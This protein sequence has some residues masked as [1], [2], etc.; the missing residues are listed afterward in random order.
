MSQEKKNTSKANKI[1]K[2]LAQDMSFRAAAV[3]ATE[4]VREMQSIQNTFPL[5]TMAVGR[6]MVAAS[7]MASQL[8][9]GQQISL[10]FR[11]DGPL[12]MFFAEANHE[13]QVRGYTSNPQLEAPS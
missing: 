12:E 11:G 10:Y 7:L 3:V 1:H 2:Y 8:K 13:G 5:A 6:S 4:V 9:D